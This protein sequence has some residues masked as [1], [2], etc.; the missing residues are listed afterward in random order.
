MKRNVRNLAILVSAL[1]AVTA[2]GFFATVPAD[3]C[4][5]CGGPLKSV[6]GTATGF[7]CSGA[8]SAAYAD[9]MTKAYQGGASCEPCQ[10][11]TGL[12][13]CSVIDYYP[14]RPPGAPT[15]GASQT[16][17]YRC[18]SCSPGPPPIQ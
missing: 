4:G 2:A 15:H 3:E 14:T 17:H 11:T 13:S 16:L 5:P 9:A 6:T 8:A 1:L 10:I 12:A 7:S 18:V